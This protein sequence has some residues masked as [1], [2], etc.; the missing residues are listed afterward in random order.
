[1]DIL[2][3]MGPIDFSA[4]EQDWQSEIWK[5]G[6]CEPQLSSR[7]R[8]FFTKAQVP[9]EL[10]GKSIME[11]TQVLAGKEKKPRGEFKREL[12]GMD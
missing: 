1:M 5:F 4:S 11:P 2:E 12:V 6:V 9:R 3:M 10:E 8:P 7:A